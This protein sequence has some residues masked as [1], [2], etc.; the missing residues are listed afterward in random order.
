MI[1]YIAVLDHKMPNGTGVD[2]ILDNG[3][4]VGKHRKRKRKVKS[5]D[6]TENNH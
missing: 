1:Y 4:V 5:S 6:N 3:T 2:A